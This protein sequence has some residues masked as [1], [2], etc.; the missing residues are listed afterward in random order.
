MK[1][2]EK[3]AQ[4]WWRYCI[5]MTELSISQQKKLKITSYETSTIEKNRYIVRDE[6]N[7]YFPFGKEMIKRRK[8]ARERS[9]KYEQAEKRE[10]R[11][12]LKKERKMKEQQE[13]YGNN[14]NAGTVNERSKSR[15]G[16]RGGW[17]GAREQ[18][19]MDKLAEEMIKF[20]EKPKPPS[21]E[22]MNDL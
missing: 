19:N 16:S 9:V 2:L 22:K 12:R 13:K 21:R 3:L 10:E 6:L 15:D 14:N 20:S 4:N 17:G 5:P 11:K 8:E 7:L 18:K 1:R